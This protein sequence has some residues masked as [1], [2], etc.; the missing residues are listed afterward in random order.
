MSEPPPAAGAWFD[1]ARPRVQAPLRAAPSLSMSTLRERAVT[2]SEHLEKLPAVEG[3]CL[4][5]SVARGTDSEAS[6]L[7]ILVLGSSAAT[8][9]RDVRRAVP[10]DLEDG[11]VALSY[12][13][14]ETLAAHLHRWSRFGAHLQ[15]EGRI[16]FDRH[17]R[18]AGI[19]A[20]APPVS[21]R[22]EIVAQ[23]RHLRNFDDLDRFGDR[24]LFVLARLHRIGRSVISRCS[25][26][27]VARVR[28]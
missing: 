20:A 6:D 21:T 19:L 9:L 14:P 13:T 24:F 18:M 16:L 4:F 10:G 5:G 8:T 17:G 11:R 15:R 12:H 28:S 25:P 22:Q 23:Y 3:V 27:M 7:D 1:S 2:L 26:R